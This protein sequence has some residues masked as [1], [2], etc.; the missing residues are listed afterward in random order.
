MQ[1][2]RKTLKPAHRFRISVRTYRY[3]MRA[4]AHVDSRRLRMDYLQTRSSDCSRRAHSFLSFRFR[5]N[6]L[7]AVIPALLGGKWDP[8]RPGD[9]RLRNLSN[10]VEGPSPDG[11]LPPC[12][13]SPVPEPC[14]Y[15]GT[16]HQ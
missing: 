7:S 11:A 16:K 14:F 9:D 4:I 5:H 12:Q 3:V 2:R 1:V 13:R 6:F 10:G 8:A 15:P